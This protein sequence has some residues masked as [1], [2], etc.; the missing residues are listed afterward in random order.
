[1]LALPQLRNATSQALPAPAD[2]TKQNPSLPLA[3]ARTR[4]ANCT[5]SPTRTERRNKSPPPIPQ[6]AKPTYLSMACHLLATTRTNPPP[7][8]ATSRSLAAQTNA[9]YQRQPCRALATDCICSVPTLPTTRT[10]SPRSNVDQPN[11]HGPNP[12][13]STYLTNPGPAPATTLCD[14]D[15]DDGPHLH[16][17]NPANST[18]RAVAPHHRTT[19]LPLA[20]SLQPGPTGLTMT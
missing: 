14:P 2:P 13:N 9:T 19:A 15:H 17:P 20:P 6:Q 7:F 16:M 5:S 12:I 18:Y 8:I 1:M 4:L 10:A 11:R 3:P